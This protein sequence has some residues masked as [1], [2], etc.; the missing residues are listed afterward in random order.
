MASS[1]PTTPTTPTA[2]APS[3]VLL[4]RAL[5]SFSPAT[6]SSSSDGDQSRS[7]TCL[8][9]ERGQ[10]LRCFNKDPSGWWDGQ[11]INGDD[12]VATSSSSRRGWFP[13]NYVQ[14]LREVPLRDA[15]HQQ[16]TTTIVGARRLG[17]EAEALMAQIEHHADLLEAAVYSRM[18]QSYQPTT[19]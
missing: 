11:V 10:L 7:Q 18:K 3:T 16:A 5:H 15:H 1:P 2:A 14:V 12:Q 9:F 4:V 8:S 19:A 17:P 6:L 13:S